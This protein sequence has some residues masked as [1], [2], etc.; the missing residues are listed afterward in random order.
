MGRNLFGV[1]NELIFGPL[2]LHIFLCDLPF[3][4]FSSY[5]DDITPYFI[6][7]DIEDV[8]SMVLFTAHKKKFSIK[9]FFSKSDQI[10]SILRIW[11]HLLKKSFGKRHFLCSIF[12]VLYITNQ[13]LTQTNATLYGLLMT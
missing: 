1:H 10:R 4:D 7:N 8:F 12:N 6:G 3:N 9:D 2:L 5:E 11:S 13:K